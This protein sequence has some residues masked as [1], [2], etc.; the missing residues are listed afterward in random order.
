VE[1]HI[2]PLLRDLVQEQKR[3][4]QQV[5]VP[6]SNFVDVCLVSTSWS[7]EVSCEGDALSACFAYLARFW[8]WSNPWQLE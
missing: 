5:R 2:G 1:L 7:R 4:V 3:Q 6:F 8:S